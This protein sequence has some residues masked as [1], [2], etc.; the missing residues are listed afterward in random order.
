MR[1]NKL[2]I[3]GILLL[4]KP[5]GLSSNHALQRVKRL[6]Q[7]EKAGHAGTLD[8]MATGL[9]PILFGEASK[10]AQSGLD[11]N[12]SYE[13]VIKLG[14]STTT[15]DATGEVL[16]EQPVP[17]ITDALL[18]ALQKNFHGPMQQVPPMY[19]ALK[20][21]GVPLYRL[22]R[23]GEVVERAARDFIIH[24]LSLTK[25]D[26]NHL[27]LQVTCSKGTYIRTLA[28]D[29][30]QSINCVAHLVALR[31]TAVGHVSAPMYTLESLEAMVS[32]AEPLPPLLLPIDSFLC[33][34]PKIQLSEAHALALFQGKK[35][36]YAEHDPANFLPDQTIRLYT[37]SGYFCG[38]GVLD[39]DYFLTSRRLVA[40]LTMN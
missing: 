23:Q 1:T 40:S 31:R 10:F 6:F 16:F 11:A 9:L 17:E 5:Q 24:A 4:D 19:S 27:R 8:P 32:R 35:I 38:L 15:G 18:A 36:A 34:L 39:V 25:I 21:A 29:I 12:K 37:E 33:D 28:E 22:A 20:K 30:A 7:A 26:A 3:H 13:A 14:V 2:P